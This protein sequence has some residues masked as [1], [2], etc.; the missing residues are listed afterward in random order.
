[1]YHASNGES[2]YTINVY[3]INPFYIRTPAHKFWTKNII[4][5]E[6]DME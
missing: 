1:M 4:K 3:K 5:V 2:V 6:F